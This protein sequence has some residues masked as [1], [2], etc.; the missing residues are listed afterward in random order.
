MGQGW[1]GMNRFFN[2]LHVSFLFALYVCILAPL[3]SMIKVHS[4]EILYGTLQ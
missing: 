2:L 4:V 3:I 1:T